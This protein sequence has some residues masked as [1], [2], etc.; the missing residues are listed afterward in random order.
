MALGADI[1]AHLLPRG[2]AD[3]DAARGHG[4]QKSRARDAQFHSVGVMTIGAGTAQVQFVDQIV[5]GGAVE[6]FPAH[7]FDQSR[8]FCGMT[9]GAGARL[10]DNFHPFGI[11]LIGLGV[12]MPPF[13]IVINAKGVAAHSRT[14]AGFR[15][16]LLK[17]SEP[18]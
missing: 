15:S 5:V 17:G 4:V 1:G 13:F 16:N 8:R 12:K 9:V 7:L 18:P 6:R 2:L 10:A 11:G 3:I 14:K